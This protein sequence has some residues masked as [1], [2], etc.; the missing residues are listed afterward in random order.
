MA[1]QYSGLP[2][3]NGNYPPNQP[4][5]S[6]QP[7]NF[8]FGNLKNS[9][10]VSEEIWGIPVDKTSTNYIILQNDFLHGRVKELEEEIHELGIKIDELE[11]DNISLETSKTSLKGYVQN[12]GELNKLSK[13]LVDIYDTSINSITKSKNE[14]EWNLKVFGIVFVA[15]EI[16]LLLYKIFN[17]D[18]FGTIEHMITN[19]AGCYVAINVY[20]PY[21]EIVG[22]RNIN[23]AQNVL[24]IKHEMK[25]ASKGNDYLNDLIDRL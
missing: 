4:A 9:G 16:I 11:D 23:S 10:L 3:M 5:E 20:K 8:Y 13:K 24:K 14:L 15:L 18:I 7:V 21:C 17:L 6:T 2:R 22:V 1:S 12:Q 25:E 19:G